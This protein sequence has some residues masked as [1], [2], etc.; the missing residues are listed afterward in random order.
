MSKASRTPMNYQ[1]KALV[2]AVQRQFDQVQKQ[3]ARRMIGMSPDV[4]K[5]N[6]AQNTL[7]TCLEAALNKLVPYEANICV[8]LAIRLASYAISAA[9]IEDQDVLV[10]QFMEAFAE[11]HLLRISE[12]KRISSEWQMNDGRVQPNFPEE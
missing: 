11:A 9:P 6:V 2:K 10:A 7:R 8:E 5:I 12:G 3:L 1:R 4:Q